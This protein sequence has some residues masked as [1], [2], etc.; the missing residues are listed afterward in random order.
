MFTPKNSNPT[1]ELFPLGWWNVY[2]HQPH[3]QNQA[4]F[5]VGFH[6]LM[7]KL[8]LFSGAKQ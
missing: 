2:D 5:P 3:D 8:S 7:K 4:Y 1:V 6:F